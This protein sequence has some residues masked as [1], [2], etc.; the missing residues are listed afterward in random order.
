[1]ERE[2]GLKRTWK[3][4]IGS[5]VWGIILIIQVVIAIFFFN[6]LG[7]IVLLFIG[8]TFFVIFIIMG[9]LAGAEFR[10]KGGVP[11]GERI[12]TTTVLVDSGIRFVAVRT[13]RLPKRANCSCHLLDA[14]CRCW[15]CRTSPLHVFASM[16]GYS[17]D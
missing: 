14:R 11:E 10:K 15:H 13:D 8:I 6:S 12:T 17:C 16:A 5:I 3:D 4:L 2:K 9:F 7:L 1:M